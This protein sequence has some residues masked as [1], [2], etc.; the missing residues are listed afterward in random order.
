M[1]IG[2]GKKKKSI[3]DIYTR[4]LHNHI[5]FSRAFPPLSLT[6]SETN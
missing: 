5:Y 6:A 4:E 2:G 1:V 3:Y